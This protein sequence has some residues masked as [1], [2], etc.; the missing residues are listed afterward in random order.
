MLDLKQVKVEVPRQWITWSLWWGR[1]SVEGY[2]KREK[3]SSRALARPGIDTDLRYQAMGKVGECAFCLHFGLPPRKL[4]W[5]PKLD[6]GWDCVYCGQKID[7]KASTT[8]K[9]IWPVTKNHFLS[10]T[11]ADV[12]FGVWAGN[13]YYEDDPV[14]TLLGWVPAY[15]FIREHKIAP[16]PANF[17]PGTKYMEARDLLA[18]DDL[19]DPLPRWQQGVVSFMS[20]A[21]WDVKL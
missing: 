15:R 16:P 9:L 21:D 6:G 4:D 18:P 3:E 8:K 2:N 20:A 17:D 5:G 11:K 14:V 13:W 1:Q 19:G 10:Q 7:V 12:F